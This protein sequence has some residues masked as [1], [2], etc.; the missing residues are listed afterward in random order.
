MV[1]HDEAASDVD[2][3]RSGDRES[4]VLIEGDR[5]CVAFGDR[6]PQ[7]SCPTRST[8]SF[9][10][11]E[12]GLTEP[13]SAATASIA[14]ELTT[15]CMVGM[16]RVSSL[17]SRVAQGACRDRRWKIVVIE[18]SSAARDELTIE[19]HWAEADRAGHAGANAGPPS[20]RGAEQ[21]W[22]TKRRHDVR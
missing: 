21:A 13:A 8:L 6:Q 1:V 16:G 3:D 2:C 11:F 4:G 12:D 17:R 20:P 7:L 19:P 22:L 10:L 9:D 14:P 15:R 5:V 18:S